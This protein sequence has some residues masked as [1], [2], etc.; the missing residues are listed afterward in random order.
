VASVSDIE[1]YSEFIKDADKITK[2]LPEAMR[3]S[4]TD[5]AS[6]WVSAAKSAASTGQEQLAASSL[7]SNSSGDGS[8]I[9]CDSPLFYGAE[10]GGQGRPE[11]MQFPPFQGSRG[12]WFFPARRE[13]EERLYEIWDKGMQLA[14]NP[15]D[16]SE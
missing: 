8:Q 6:E 12:Y 10:F 14:F 5:F 3:V 1:G 4:S 15:W 9:Y 16:R 2:N 7:M 11:T 13:N